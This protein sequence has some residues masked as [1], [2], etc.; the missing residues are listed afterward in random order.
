[1]APNKSFQRYQHTRRVAGLRHV[2][3]FNFQMEVRVVLRRN[4]VVPHRERSLPLNSEVVGYVTPYHVVVRS[5]RRSEETYRLCL[6]STTFLPL[7]DPEPFTSRHGAIPL[8]YRCVIALSACTGNAY[9]GVFVTE[10][11]PVLWEVC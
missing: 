10:I 7:F 11:S 3:H 2:K 6:S 8:Y 1:M 4:E 5:C 9:R